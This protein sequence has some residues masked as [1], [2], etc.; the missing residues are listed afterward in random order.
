MW[1]TDAYDRD[2]EG[3][4]HQEVEATE[5]VVEGLEPVLCGRGADEVATLE[6]ELPLDGGSLETDGGVA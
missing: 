4:P 3:N 1:G 5:D 2:D 6:L